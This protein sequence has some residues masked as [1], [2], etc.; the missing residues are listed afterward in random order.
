[1][2]ACALQIKRICPGSHEQQGSNDSRCSYT[3][4]STKHRRLLWIIWMSSSLSFEIQEAVND[5]SECEHCGLRHPAKAD[6][7]YP[8]TLVDGRR[9]I[10]FHI[11]LPFAALSCLSNSDQCLPIRFCPKQDCLFTLCADVWSRKL[12]WLDLDLLFQGRPHEWTP[13]LVAIMWWYE[14]CTSI[15]I[16]QCCNLVLP[17]VSRPWKLVGCDERVCQSRNK[18]NKWSSQRMAMKVDYNRHL[19]KLS[20]FMEHSLDALNKHFIRWLSPSSLPTGL[21]SET[22]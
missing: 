20:V 21:L 6:C 14:W 19:K 9:S 17:H 18:S 16:S 3:C 22:P 1:M 13:W 8:N 10:I 4:C 5:R 15:P 12:C 11:W 2:A 7:S